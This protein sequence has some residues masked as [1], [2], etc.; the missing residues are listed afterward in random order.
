MQ[1]NPIPNIALLSSPE[2]LHKT[3]ATIYWKFL[4]QTLGRF[5]LMCTVCTKLATLGKPNTAPTMR[6]PPRITSYLLR[7]IN[8]LTDKGRWLELARGEDPADHPHKIFKKLHR[9]RMR[10]PRTKKVTWTTQ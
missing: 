8:A 7:V 9:R 3:S 6:P 10:G 5:M 1:G 4:D 2:V